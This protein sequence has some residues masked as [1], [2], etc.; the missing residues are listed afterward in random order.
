M[1]KKV[2]EDVVEETLESMKKDDTEPS[3]TTP[4]VKE[5]KRRVPFPNRLKQ[6]QLDKQFHKFLEIYKNFHINILFADALAQILWKVGKQ[7]HQLDKQ[8]HQ[9]HINFHM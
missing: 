8:F 7:F 3:K 9:L 4:E 1:K 2:K 5:Y 6:H